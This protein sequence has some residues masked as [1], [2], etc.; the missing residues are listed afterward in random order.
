MPYT[1]I[2]DGGCGMCTRTVRRLAGMDK[3]HALS[4]RPCQSL[5]DSGLRG[6]TRA[7]CEKAV[8]IIAPDGHAE[9]GSRAAVRMLAAMLNHRWPNT[10]FNL[11]GVAQVMNAVYKG[12]A[13]H[14][15][16]FPGETPW[17]QQHPEDCEPTEN[18]IS[19]DL[20]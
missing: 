19:H 14:R 7:D 2:F 4:F 8:W 3:R 13:S 9:Q 5:P 11:P 15:S 17:C 10:V 16:G 18:W 1:V 20:F 12:I 6:I